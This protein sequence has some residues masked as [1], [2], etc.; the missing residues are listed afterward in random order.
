MSIVRGSLRIKIFIASDCFIV[1][2]VHMTIK[3]LKLNIEGAAVV[4]VVV[5][6]LNTVQ[7]HSIKVEMI[8]KSVSTRPC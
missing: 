6:F 1:I 7:C 3:N 4:A 5:A 8:V 2:V